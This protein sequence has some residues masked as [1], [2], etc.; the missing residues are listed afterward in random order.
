MEARVGRSKFCKK[1]WYGKCWCGGS[2]R[3]GDR[4]D[5]DVRCRSPWSSSVSPN[6]LPTKPYLNRMRLIYRIVLT[7]K[8]AIWHVC[9]CTV[10]T[11]PLRLLL[12]LPT[13][14]ARMHT[15]FERRLSCNNS[16]NPA[17]NKCTFDCNIQHQTSRRGTRLTFT[18]VLL[19]RLWWIECIN[20]KRIWAATTASLQAYKLW[21]KRIS[22]TK[23]G[24]QGLF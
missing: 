11:S 22:T 12:T 9:R 4:H 24:Y 13:L 23:P 19:I 20:H 10:T 15:N 16:S 14:P 1:L 7:S 21:Y 5:V 8:P 2:Y 6:A 18:E 3:S 17:H